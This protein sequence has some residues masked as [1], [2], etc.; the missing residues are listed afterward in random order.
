MD[1]CRIGARTKHAHTPLVGMYQ[2]AEMRVACKRPAFAEARPSRL[3]NA[4]ALARNER[5]AKETGEESKESLALKLPYL[6]K[7]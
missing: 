5:Y 3:K 2:N 4:L 6:L 7:D 1:T